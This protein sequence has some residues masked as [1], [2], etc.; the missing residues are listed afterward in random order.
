MGAE[1]AVLQKLLKPSPYGLRGRQDLA[2]ETGYLELGAIPES[3]GQD[4]DIE[5]PRRAQ[6]HQ[7]ETGT[8]NQSS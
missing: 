8:F 5:P 4:V 3:V 1:L 2:R 6:I 7:L